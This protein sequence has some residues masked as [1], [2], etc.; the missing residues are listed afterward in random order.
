MF[1][2]IV[3][4]NLVVVQA[5]QFLTKLKLAQDLILL[6]L[7]L[8]GPPNSCWT[9]SSADASN[10]SWESSKLCWFSNDSL[11]NVN[12]A[13]SKS[14]DWNPW[15]IL[16][17]DRP[18]KGGEDGK[19][20]DDRRQ[21]MEVWISRAKL[22]WLA[23]GCLTLSTSSISEQTCL[24]F[25]NVFK[26]FWDHFHILSCY[27]N[28]ISAKGLLHSWFLE[29]LERTTKRDRK[30]PTFGTGRRPLESDSE[31][32]L[33]I[34][35]WLQMSEKTAE[36]RRTNAAEKKTAMFQ[37]EL[38]SARQRHQNVN[39]KR[40]LFQRSSRVAGSATHS[41]R[42][43]VRS[44]A[45]QPICW[46]GNILSLASELAC[47]NDY[48]EIR[49]SLKAENFLRIAASLVEMTKK[50]RSTTSHSL[51]IEDWNSVHFICCSRTC[52]VARSARN[53]CPIS[54]SVL[55]TSEGHQ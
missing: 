8:T 25:W 7:C 17:T 43:Y 50:L 2:W 41:L 29:G 37:N 18:A 12:E 21:R 49:D 53:P 19:D 39:V 42:G 28:W 23:S 45:L 51:Q 35:D 4:S 33:R 32:E 47:R 34:S 46:H 55:E 38:H 6:P 3:G 9:R 30:R 40:V 22:Q 10:F 15:T 1:W 27:V 24:P 36:A 54:S 52:K 44:T 11:V 13:E 31:V 16:Q 14:S 20:A 48:L 26:L 5:Q